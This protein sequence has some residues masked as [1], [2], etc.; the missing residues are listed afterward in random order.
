MSLAREVPVYPPV[1]AELWCLSLCQEGRFL[2]N[3]SGYVLLMLWRALYS[4]VY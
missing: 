4:Q 2:S 1:F 3:S